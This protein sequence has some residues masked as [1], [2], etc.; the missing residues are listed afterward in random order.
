MIYDI[1]AA[2]KNLHS[3]LKPNGVLLVTSL[4]TS[5]I[6]RVLGVDPWG[7]YWRFTAQSSKI[8]FEEIFKPGN[9]KVIPY[10]NVLTAISFLHGLASQELTK[11]E[12]DYNDP[13]YE[14]LV[15]VRALKSSVV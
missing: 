7:E 1:R 10:G 5:K 4:G 13:K 14:V 12:L 2:I 8:M 6:C 11:E 3:I 9:V 15:G